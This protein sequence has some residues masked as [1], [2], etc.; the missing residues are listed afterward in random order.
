MS[1]TG[2]ATIDKHMGY[3]KVAT[4][5]LDFV[6]PFFIIGTGLALVASAFLI[7]SNPIFFIV[8]YVLQIF[9][10]IVAISMSNAWDSVF[11]GSLLSSTAN[12]FTMWSF[13]MKNAPIVSLVL[14]TIFAIAIYLKGGD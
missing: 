3:A 7:R 12:Q 13:F 1:Q 4:L 9:F 11:T 2:N 6:A 5:S 14:G 8:L 10:A